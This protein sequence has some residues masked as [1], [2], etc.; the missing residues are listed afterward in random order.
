M[1]GRRPLPPP[2]SGKHLIC[3]IQSAK[4][5]KMSCQASSWEQVR[6]PH[7]HFACVHKMLGYAPPSPGLRVDPSSQR[8]E[9]GDPLVFLCSTEGGT[10]K[11]K[12]HFY[13]DGVEITSRKEGLLEPSS[14]PT[15]PLQNASLRIPHA[16]FNHSGE[17][18]CSYEEKRSN[19]WIMSSL[20]QGVNI[21]VE[22]AS[23]PHEQFQLVEKK[24][25]GDLLGMMESQAATAATSSSAKVAGG[26]HG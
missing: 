13:K 19:R 26:I 20:S 14:E 17:F 2:P 8:V 23:P 9:E 11:K 25:E 10:T 15:N 18:A 21:T 3:C 6:D 5:K 1:G 4:K 7:A 22:P 24:E 16:S 12:F